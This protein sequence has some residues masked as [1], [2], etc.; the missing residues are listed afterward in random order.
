MQSQRLCEMRRIQNNCPSIGELW[1]HLCSRANEGEIAGI[2][3]DTLLEKVIVAGHFL[4]GPEPDRLLGS[5]DALRKLVW[6][7]LPGRV[8][9]ADLYRREAALLRRVDEVRS[10]TLRYAGVV[11]DEAG[12]SIFDGYAVLRTRTSGC[13][14]SAEQEELSHCGRRQGLEDV[15]GGSKRRAV[16]LELGLLLLWPVIAGGQDEDGLSALDCPNCA[17]GVGLALS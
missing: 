6:E 15:A 14:R 7:G 1:T 11:V 8:S 2:G 10:K 5:F 13:G 3:K 9:V 12:Y 4:S 16:D 17:S